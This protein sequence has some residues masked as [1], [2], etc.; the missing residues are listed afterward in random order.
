MSSLSGDPGG[1]GKRSLFAARQGPR[2]AVAR[3][4]NTIVL[5]SL[6][7]ILK[8][9][10]DFVENLQSNGSYRVPLFEIHA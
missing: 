9:K 7:R 3:R 1:W 10:I 5:S 2:A 6:L 8:V 4:R